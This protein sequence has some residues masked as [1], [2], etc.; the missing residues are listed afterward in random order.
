MRVGDS[1]THALK[2]RDA[3]PERQAA[4]VG[5]VGDRLPVDELHHQKRISALGPTA[6]DYASHVGVLDPGEQA[7][8]A[9]ESPLRVE[10]CGQADELD[11]GALLVGG[12]R[13][14]S[15]VDDAHA[16]L[17]E[18]V[19]E[20][21]R[22]DL[23]PCLAPRVFAKRRRRL[24]SRQLAGQ[25]VEMVGIE[26]PRGRRAP[27]ERARHLRWS[28]GAR[29]ARLKSSRSDRRPNRRLRRI[30]REGRGRASS[31][32]RFSWIC[33]A[34]RQSATSNRFGVRRDRREGRRGSRAL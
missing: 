2:Q 12:V 8:F 15:R 9:L 4:G 17:A 29:P 11:G 20:V 5:P 22:S 24:E 7:A 19:V 27:G 21:P 25:L 31:E 18:H 28:K 10:R 34:E 26:T 3:L 6:V 1:V 30:G 13:T 33:V 23:L 16:S 14:V 32:W